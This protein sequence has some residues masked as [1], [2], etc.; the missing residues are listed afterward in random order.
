M[1][2]ILQAFAFF[3]G[4]SIGAVLG[5]YAAQWVGQKLFRQD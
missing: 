3:L 4:S 1:N 5:V 2:D